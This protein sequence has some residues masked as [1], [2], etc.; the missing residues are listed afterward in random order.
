MASKKLLIAIIIVLLPIV[1]ALETSM[2]IKTLS[3][4]RVSVIVREA[5]KLTTLESFHKDTAGGEVQ[6]LTNQDPTSLDLLVT[7][8]KDTITIL[9]KK[10]EAVK[11]GE[12]L[13]IN[14]VPGDVSLKTQA[15][16]DAEAA[17]QAAAETPEPKAPVEETASEETPVETEPAAETQTESVEELKNS[18]VSGLAIFSNKETT[19]KI[20]YGLGIIIALIVIVC[21]FFF[22]RKKIKSKDSMTDSFKVR[23][24]SDIKGDHYIDRKLR[25]AEKRIEEAKREIEQIKN[26]DSR[27]RQLKEQ[28][29][30]D[31]K[32]L[33]RLGV[34]VQ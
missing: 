2:T 5:G 34:N 3:N 10:F 28:Y 32:E 18:K 16:I 6:I 24:L 21:I 25:D 9:N 12:K 17:A 27:V 7:L 33:K 29:E 8:K 1:F 14:F 26:K 15:E 13:V 4:H 22:V 19:K 20:Y 31:K 23:K 30:H 11:S